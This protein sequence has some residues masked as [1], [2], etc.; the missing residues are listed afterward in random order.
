[1]P[2]RSSSQISSRTAPKPSAKISP[3]VAVT[4][5]RVGRSR[6]LTTELP[7]DRTPRRTRR[8]ER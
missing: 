4:V 6:E 7:E 2:P 5:T 8:S 3:T 1:M